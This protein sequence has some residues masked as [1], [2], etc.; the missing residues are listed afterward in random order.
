MGGKFILTKTLV[1]GEACGSQMRLHW[2]GVPIKKRAE[3]GIVS[4]CCPLLSF[5]HA[6]PPQSRARPKR[7]QSPNYRLGTQQR[8]AASSQGEAPSH[9]VAYF[10]KQYWLGHLQAPQLQLIC[11][12]AE[13]DGLRHKDVR[14]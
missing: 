3:V 2:M 7:A 5:K 9:L 10:L 12:A 4:V 14:R 8:L 11:A 6:M 13:E 1:F